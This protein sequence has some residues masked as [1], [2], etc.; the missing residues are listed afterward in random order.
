MTL[1]TGTTKEGERLVVMTE[2]V[3]DMFMQALCEAR[4]A[5][6]TV[7]F[8]TMK[9]GTMAFYAPTISV[10]PVPDIADADPLT[11]GQED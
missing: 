3:F 7:D 5:D 9:S 2:E 1:P 6:Y 11:V 10:T 4:D 8:G